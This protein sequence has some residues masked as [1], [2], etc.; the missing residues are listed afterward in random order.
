MPNPANPH[1]I[2]A[3]A[4]QRALLDF[5]DR[6]DFED[7]TR[8][9]VAGFGDSG[10]GADAGGRAWDFDETAFLDGE[11]PETVNPSLWRQAQL[12]KIAGLFTIHPRIHQIR[13]HDLANMTLI[14]GDTG[15]IVVDCL[16]SVETARESLALA[17]KHLGARPVVAV[18]YTHTHADHFGGVRGIVTEGMDVP[19]IAPDGFMDFAI[20]EN[21]LA[22]NAMSRRAQYQFG[23]PLPTGP[24]GHIS[25]GLGH[26]L[27]QGALS[28]L[29]P[30]DLIKAT[31]ETR[32]IDGV[33][34]EFQMASGSEAPAEFMFYLPP[35]PGA[36]HGRGHLAPH[37]QHPDPARGQR[38]ATR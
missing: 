1:T 2:A 19:I 34:F 37:A 30:T 29:P 31:G 8:G 4:A 12:T 26:R 9:F 22:G 13:G 36:V 25:C 33:A 27:S 21:V 23:T 17:N 7:A 5:G 16:F 35:V 15:W 28:F 20:S 18:L 38:C 11:C 3:N 32:A 24:T 6:Q 14:E 10:I